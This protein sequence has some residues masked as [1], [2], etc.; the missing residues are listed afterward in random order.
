MKCSC[1]TLVFLFAIVSFSS[2]AKK[3][4]IEPQLLVSL[5]TISFS[6]EVGISAIALTC[7]DQWSIS[8]SAS[9]GLHVSPIYPSYNTSPKAPD[10]TGMSST[11]IQLAANIN[12]GW[13]IGNTMEAPSGETGWGNPS[14][15]ESYV[16]FVKKCGFNA[17]RI[18][19]A[20]NLG[21]LRNAATAQID[22]NWLSRVKEVVGYC[23]NNNMYVLLNIHWDGGWLEQNCTVAKKDSVNAKQ[24]AFWEQIATTMRDFDEHLMFASA[25]EPNTNSD[26]T[27]M[28]ALMSYHQ[29]FVNAVRSTGGR[30][31]YRT[32]VIQGDNQLI[33]V[34]AFP[35]DPTPNRIM[36]EDH[37]YTPYQF[38]CLAADATWG[39]MF[40]YWG[41]GH[42]STIEPDRNATWGEESDQITYFQKIE[43][44]FIDKGIPVI[45]GEY[46]AYRRTPPK[47]LATQ[48]DAVDYWITYVTRQAIT[49]GIKP[50]FW[51]TGGALDRRNDTVLD[52]C[53]INAILTG[54]K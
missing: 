49:H 19:C 37:N 10:A 2:Y 40:Y 13:N 3:V 28:A 26:T 52:Q 20:W 17:I 51:D 33:N 42:H 11:A 29:T 27:Q 46:G 54:S 9:S 18:P 35:T 16:K 5:T 48:N 47:D 15:T 32:L 25:N 44:K 22:P 43:T 53:T 30:N 7:N 31:T 50:F 38:T 21:H 6:A 45:M 14:I 39:R 8:N 12:L 34:N 41:D 1:I 24:K 23:V 36:Y 4:D